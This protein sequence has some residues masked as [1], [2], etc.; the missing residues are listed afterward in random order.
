MTRP[1]S[2]IVLVSPCSTPV[3]P[4]A[5]AG[6]EVIVYN[7][8]R[9]L[10][11]VTHVLGQPGSELPSGVTLIP[12]DGHPQLPDALASTLA[13]MPDARIC[14]HSG[15]RF[16][17]GDDAAR[18]RRVFHVAPQYVYRPA[19]S[20][21]VAFV[22]EFLRAAFSQFTGRSYDACAVLHNGVEA[23]ALPRDPVCVAREV[24]YIGRVNRLK[25]IDMAAAVCAARGLTLVVYGGL[26]A[27]A[28]EDIVFNDRTHLRETM[29]RFPG[30]VRYE[31]PLRDIA[32]KRRRLAGAR[33][34]LIPSRE[35]ESCSLVALEGVALGVPVVA[36]AHGGLMEYVAD[37][38]FLAPY[39]GRWAEDI[40]SLGDAL[41]RATRAEPAHPALPPSF[42]ADAMATRY[43]SWLGV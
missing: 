5:A 3:S 31:G 4:A 16:P 6:V 11:G 1:R 13:R 42:R 29:A 8:A 36:F 10:P 38:L 22:S 21:R 39:R 23:P 9:H 33:C 14:D 24:V 43:Q 28:P 27:S 26:G 7:L 40:R 30:V 19:P 17:A 37:Q 2:P 25:G 20:S 35:P 18:V 12:V 15:C 41:D 32:S 34:L